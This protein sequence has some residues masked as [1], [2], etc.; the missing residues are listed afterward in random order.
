[1]ENSVVILAAG[2]SKRIGIP[3]L[4][5][6][7]NEGET[8]LEHILKVYADFGCTRHVVVHNDDTDMKML[9]DIR[10]KIKLD[11]EYII[12]EDLNEG[13]FYSLQ[14]G[15]IELFDNNFAFIHNVDSPF[16]D[17]A[18]LQVMNENRAPS[19]YTVPAFDQNNGHPILLS[20]EVIKVL[21]NYPDKNAVLND[22]LKNFPKKIVEVTNKGI[23]VNINTREEYKIH[24]GDMDLEAI[25]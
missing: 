8:F 3:K 20:P 14:L 23:H 25:S 7:Y 2:R 10:S 11:I 15:L 13:R 16:I 19:G 18:T 22:V 5:L 17:N 9:H 1:M 4:F 6:P 12:N 24:F 21:R